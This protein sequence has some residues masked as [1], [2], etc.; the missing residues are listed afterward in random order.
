[1]CRDNSKKERDWRGVTERPRVSREF[2]AQLDAEPNTNTLS[3]PLSVPLLP[4]SV[5]L[6]STELVKYTG[7]LGQINADKGENLLCF[8]CEHTF[9]L[10]SSKAPL[11]VFKSSLLS[12]WERNPSS[13]SCPSFPSISLAPS[14]LQCFTRHCIKVW[15]NDWEAKV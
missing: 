6:T 2:W 15:W 1:M 8:P 11:C 4:A 5:Q 13:A 9:K 14:L 7:C 12:Q 3:H 10:K